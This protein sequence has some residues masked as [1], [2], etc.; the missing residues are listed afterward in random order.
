MIHG[1]KTP[2]VGYNTQYRP[3]KQKNSH[4]SIPRGPQTKKGKRELF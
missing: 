4:G 2:N 1:A 3:R